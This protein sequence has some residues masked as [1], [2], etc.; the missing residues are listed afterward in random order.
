VP[1]DS[2]RCT[3]TVQL[4]TRHLRVSQ[5]A[6][7]YNSPDRPVCH[8][9]VRCATGLSGAPAE[10][11]LSSATVDCTVPLTALQ[12]AAEGRT[13]VRGAPDSEQCLFGATPDYPVPLE[14]KG[15]NGQQ[16]SNPNS[17]VTWLAHQTASGAPIDSSHPQR[18]FWWLRAINTPNH[19]HSNHPSI[20]N[21]AFNTRA[22]HFT[23]KTQFK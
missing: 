19:H 20:H 16:R 18:L 12:C 23:P 6:L 13:E 9:T 1:P 8:R 11:R 14:D 3:S 5:A 17:W 2:V 22:I 15:S 7:C 21:S 4:R 10:Q